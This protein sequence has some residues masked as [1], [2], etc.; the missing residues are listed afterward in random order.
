[1]PQELRDRLALDRG[2]APNPLL[3][4]W[5]KAKAQHVPSVSLGM[6]FVIRYRNACLTAG[7][8]AHSSGQQGAL[9]IRGPTLRQLAGSASATERGLPGG[10]QGPGRGY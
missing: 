7:P 2:R 4:A 3:Q 6:P 8:M 5:V 9:P 10:R 1:M